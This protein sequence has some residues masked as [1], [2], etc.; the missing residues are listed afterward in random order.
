MTLLGPSGCGKTTVL[1]LIAGFETPDEGAIQM[2]GADVAARPPHRR[3]V[4]MV[5]QDYALFPHLTVPGERGLPAPGP[6]RWP[7]PS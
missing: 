7:E 5:F 3:E 1:N 2:D 4:G 6:R